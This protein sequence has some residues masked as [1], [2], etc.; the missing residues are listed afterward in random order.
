MFKCT[1]REAE[2]FIAEKKA[3][4]EQPLETNGRQNSLH[5]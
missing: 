1:E 4:L 3:K 5:G 2:E